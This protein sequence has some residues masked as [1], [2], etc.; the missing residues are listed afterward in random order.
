MEAPGLG[1]LQ[2]VRLDFCRVPGLGFVGLRV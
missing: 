1:F 2:A